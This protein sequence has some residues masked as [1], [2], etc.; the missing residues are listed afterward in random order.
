[1]DYGNIEGVTLPV[2]K[3]VLGSMVCST[4]DLGLTFDL[5]DAFVMAGGSCIDTARIYNGGKSE[6]AVGAWLQERRNRNNIV[7]LGKGAHHDS[8]GPRV[9]PEHITADLNTSLESMQTDYMDLYVLHRDDPAVPV[10]PIVECLNEQQ[11]EGKIRAFGGSNWTPERLQEAND[12]AAEHKLKP[13]VVSSPHFSLAIPSGP[14]WA[15]CVTLDS[16]AMSWYQKH[17]FPVFAW[18][19]QASGF[20]TGR[21]APDVHTNLDVERIFYSDQNWE[22]LRRAKETGE[23][24]GVSANTIALAYVLHQPFPL[25]ALIGPRTLQELNSSMLA[26]DIKLSA[27]ELRYLEV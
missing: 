12:Y 4:E 23:A 20:F 8:S 7:V 25:Y 9:T 11:R 1:M 13:F 27:D 17:Q 18:S 3:L 14:M 26:I 19:S 2:S 6:N 22:R 10:G 15:G 21:Y 5:L 16:A 24:H